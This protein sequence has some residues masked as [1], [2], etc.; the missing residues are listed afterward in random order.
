MQYLPLA[1]PGQHCHSC[2]GLVRQGYLRGYQLGVG[3]LAV[4]MF[5]H[6]QYIQH[7]A[8]H[9]FKLR[10]L[11]GLTAGGDCAMFKLRS[12]ALPLNP[13]WAYTHQR[14]LQAQV[15]S[16]PGQA[17]GIRSY[18]LFQQFQFRFR[19][20]LGP[21]WVR[22]AILAARSELTQWFSHDLV[23]FP[24]R[25]LLLSCLSRAAVAGALHL[26]QQANPHDTT[27]PITQCRSVAA[28]P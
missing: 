4:R 15:L 17:R 24:R 10:S 20:K 16:K 9:D 11:P 28:L 12:L 26:A 18:L 25:C 14:R 27:L 21:G 19:Q 7:R 3:S 8:K 5:D 23:A 1:S 2:Q 13:G 22:F 6:S